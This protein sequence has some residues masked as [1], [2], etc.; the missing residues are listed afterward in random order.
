MALPS[1]ETQAK[2]ASEAAQAFVDHFYEALSKRRPINNFYAST[3]ARLTAAGVKPDISING[4]L[5][6]DASAYEALLETQGGP[7]SYD[8]ASFDAQPVN[9]CFRIG[10]P[11][12][13]AGAGAGRD[14]TAAAAVRN[15]DRLSFAV[16]DDNEPLEK[17]FNEA[18]LLVPH[19]EAWGR[20]ASRGLRKW[21]IVSQNFRA[22]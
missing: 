15:G 12:L 22:L 10:E 14:A 4:L 3:S 2:V 21:V 8:I 6:P 19:W 20:N 9:P 11:E 7:V 13:G 1:P 18:F 17:P 5:V 16:Q